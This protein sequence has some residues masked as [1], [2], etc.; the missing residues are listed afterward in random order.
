MTVDIGEAIG[1]AMRF[2]A[3]R[4]EAEEIRR[5]LT[6]TIN[7]AIKALPR[8][9]PLVRNLIAEVLPEVKLD[10]GGVTSTF[11]VRTVQRALNTLGESLVVDG[12]LGKQTRAAI[13]R[14][15]VRHGLTP[16]GWPGIRTVMALGAAVAKEKT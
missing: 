13:E 8:V 14:F 11:D 10:L 15:Q 6:P 9:A 16:D 7:E 1:I 2:L 5:L 3:H 12:V 4:E